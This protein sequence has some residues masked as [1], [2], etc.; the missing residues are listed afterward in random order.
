MKAAALILVISLTGWFFT[1]PADAGWYQV[2]QLTHCYDIQPEGTISYTFQVCR[3][4]YNYCE[5]GIVPCASG[6]VPFTGSP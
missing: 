4:G 2:S 1:Q 5:P 6:P 3:P